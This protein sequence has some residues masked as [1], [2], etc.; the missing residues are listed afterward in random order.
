MPDRRQVDRREGGRRKISVPLSTFVFVVIIA[1]IT[2][3]SIIL[4]VLVNKKAYNKG[5]DQAITDVTSSSGNY[6]DDFTLEPESDDSSLQNSDEVMGI[7]E[8]TNNE[9]DTNNT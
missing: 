6:S 4:C 3:L 5:Y 2:F 7:V 8:S 9:S 1:I